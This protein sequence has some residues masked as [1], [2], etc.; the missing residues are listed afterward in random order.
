VQEGVLRSVAAIADDEVAR[1]IA[2]RAKAP[3]ASVED[4]RRRAALRA[5]TTAGLKM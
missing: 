3:F 1:W 4:F 5:A 2:E